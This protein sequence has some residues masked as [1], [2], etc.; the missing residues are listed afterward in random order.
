[1]A[2]ATGVDRALTPNVWTRPLHLFSIS[3]QNRRSPLRI[4]VLWGEESHEA[5]AR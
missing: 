5:H 1:M 2:A 3:A 4:V